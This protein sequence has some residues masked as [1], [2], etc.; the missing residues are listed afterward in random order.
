KPAEWNGR[1]HFC[2]VAARVMRHI[3]INHAEARRA[4]KRGGGQAHV[5]LSEGL[6]PAPGGGREVDV[7][8]LDEALKDLEA[9]DERQCRVVELRFVRGLSVEESARVLDGSDRTVE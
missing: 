7:L 4:A 9:L 3:L 8:A 6:M 5:T 1:A 2:A